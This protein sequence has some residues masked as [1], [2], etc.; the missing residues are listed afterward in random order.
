MAATVRNAY[1]VSEAVFE[2]R[3]FPE[4]R[5]QRAALFDGQPFAVSGQ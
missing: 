2:T 4:R 1:S 5:L 3:Q